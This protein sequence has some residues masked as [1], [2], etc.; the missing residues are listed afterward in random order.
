MKGW[1]TLFC[2]QVHSSGIGG[3][4]S[5]LKNSLE[6]PVVIKRTEPTTIEY[7]ACGK[8]HKLSLSDRT[9]SCDCGWKHDRDVNDAL[10]ILKEGLGL[11]P[12]WAV[13]LDR[14]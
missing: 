13:G 10:V 11:D 6:T 4:K 14:P 2:K 8:K 7:F 1:S 9:I 12:N 5:R 3:L